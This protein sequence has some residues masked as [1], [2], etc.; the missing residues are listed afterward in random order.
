MAGVYFFM[1]NNSED[2]VHVQITPL[3]IRIN[4]EF[5]SFGSISNYSVI[6]NA[7]QAIYLQLFTQKSMIKTTNLHINNQIALELEQVLP[8]FLQ[9]AGEGQMKVIDRII[10]LLKL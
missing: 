5:L 10:N 9:N 6:Y 3:G 1:E 4:N 2:E 7:D 8:H